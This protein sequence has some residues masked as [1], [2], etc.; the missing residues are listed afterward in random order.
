MGWRFWLTGICAIGALASLGIALLFLTYSLRFPDPLSLAH[1]QHAPVIHVVARDGTEIAARGVSADYMPLD[2]LPQHLTDAVIATEDRR[3]FAHWGVDPW[4]LMRAAWANVRAGRFAQGGSTLTQQLAK[5][6]FLSGERKLWRKVEELTFALWLELRLTKRDILELYLNR[7][8]FGGGAYGVEAASQRYFGK[9]ARQTTIAEAAVLAGLL[10]APTKYSPA[11]NPHAARARE[12]VVLANMVATGS[13]TLAASQVEA[14]SPSTFVTLP[15]K[16]ATGLEYAVEYALERMPPIR[17]W[18]GIGNVEVIV[19][20]T[21]D[22]GLQKTAHQ[23]VSRQLDVHGA[24]LQASQAGLVVMD[25]D[26]GIRA[27]IGGRSYAQSQYNRAVKA[28]RQ[29]GSAFKPIVYLAAIESGLTPDTVAYDLPLS[30]KGWSPRN[31]NGIYQGEMTLRHALAGSVNTVA[32]RMYLDLAQGRVVE[33]AHR[34]GIASEL[35][36][37]PALALGASEVTLLELTQAYAV[38]ANRGQSV[39]PHVIEKVRLVSGAVLYQRPSAKPQMLVRAADVAAMDDM[40]GEVMATGTGKRA[41]LKTHPAAGKTGTTQDFRD[42]WF[43][44]YTSQLTAGVWVG[45]DGAQPMNRVM[46][47]SLPARIWHDVMEA[48]HAGLPIVALPGRPLP[49]HPGLSVADRSD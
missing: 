6:L 26:G 16:A 27:L 22:A 43:M 44:G 11:N 32:V 47:G 14:D 25:R 15:Q 18:G 48:A 45:N 36:D 4:G 17:G 49:A 34:L 29:P 35:H 2:F 10:K 46:G 1:K 40:L 24:A 31:D 13:L 12:R 21:L 28:R 19:E 7:V 20:T 9:S 23:A 42:A 5:N 3:F 37:A 33:T 38:L 30:V 8:Y 41:T 39:M